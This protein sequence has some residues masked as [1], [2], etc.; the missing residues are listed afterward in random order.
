MKKATFRRWRRPKCSEC[1]HPFRNHDKW[2]DHKY[3]FD[4]SKPWQDP[5]MKQAELFATKAKEAKSRGRRPSEI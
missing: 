2:K 3:V 5:A 1:G 4:P